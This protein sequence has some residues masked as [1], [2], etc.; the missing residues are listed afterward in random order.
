VPDSAVTIERLGDIYV[1]E[2]WA[3]PDSSEHP[4]RSGEVNQL[5][6]LW[7]TLQ[8]R[9][10]LYTLRHPHFLR[11]VPESV[12]SIFSRFRAKRNSRPSDDDLAL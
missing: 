9:L 6:G 5:N 8:P 10:F 2:R 11:K 12:G 3:D 4:R 7:K 1:R